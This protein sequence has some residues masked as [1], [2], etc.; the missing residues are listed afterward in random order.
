VLIVESI[1]DCFG[2]GWSLYKPEIGEQFRVEIYHTTSGKP[3]A[4]ATVTLEP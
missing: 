4:F 3:V 1:D 2:T